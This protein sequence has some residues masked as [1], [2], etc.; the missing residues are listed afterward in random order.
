MRTSPS[1]SVFCEL[2]RASTARCGHSTGGWKAGFVNKSRM[3]GRGARKKHARGRTVAV[4]IGVVAACGLVLAGPS[5]AADPPAGCTTTAA[6]TTCVFAYTGASQAWTVP[7]GVTSAVFDVYGAAG[8]S[9]T[10]LSGVLNGGSGGKGGHVQATVALTPGATLHLRVGGHGIVGGE[11]EFFATPGTLTAAGGFNG[12]GTASVTCSGCATAVGGAGGG[13]SDVRTSADGLDD[14]LLVAGGGGG[15]GVGGRSA[16]VVA[17]GGDSAG[18]APTLTEPFGGPSVTCTG[19]GAG[20]LIGPGAAGGGTGCFGGSAGSGADGGNSTDFYGI[21]AGGGG[22]FGGG[23]GAIGLPNGLFPGTGGGG[24]SDSPD[25]ASPPLGTSA[26]TV[27]DGVRSG[28]GLI[29]VTYSALQGN[30]GVTQH[31][32]EG[33]AMNNATLGT[34]TDSNTSMVAGDFT[35]TTCWNDSGTPPPNND[36]ATTTV[37]GSNG[38]FTVSGSH[39]FPEEGS[40][41]AVTSVGGADGSVTLHMPAVVTDAAL[42]ATGVKATMNAGKSQ[43]K[44]VANFKDAD[45]AGTTSDYSATINWGDG[46]STTGGLIAPNGTGGWSVTGSH[47]YAKPGNGY[48]VSV[49]IHD[50]GGAQASTVSVIKVNK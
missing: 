16:G 49:T 39:T 29:T 3:G 30:D 33:A 44:L 17:D 15:A 35:A 43:T 18:T 19:G 10:D 28:D 11:A 7:A 47:K 26:V 40:F 25:P 41:T 20:T 24:G 5:S 31:A 37:S 12:G 48:S 2:F 45:P 23:A 6:I 50:S 38:S 32:V 42:S 9:F 34:F 22:Y 8:G 46:T 27:T 14:R 13:A 36:C 21:G 1:S 4:L